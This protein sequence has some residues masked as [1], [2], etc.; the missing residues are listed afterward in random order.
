[1][2]QVC[3]QGFAYFGT[4]WLTARVGGDSEVVLRTP[5]ALAGVL[6]VVY[7]Y[8]LGRTLY[9]PAVGLLSG[10]L[11]ATMFFPVWY[12][13]EAR[14]YAFMMLLTTAQI[15]YAYRSV[16]ESRARDWLGLAV[17][18]VLGLYNHYVALLPTAA[19]GVFVLGALAA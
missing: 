8:K 15:L 17:A 9:T 10:L 19:C 3:Q 12:S 7:A 5:S 4:A 11:I 6:T 1:W 14:P 16:R 2:C 18:T 13:Q